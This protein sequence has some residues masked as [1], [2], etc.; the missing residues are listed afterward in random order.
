MIGNLV[1][2]KIRVCFFA[3]RS[4]YSSMFIINMISTLWAKDQDNRIV[5]WFEY[6]V[7]KTSEQ[8]E[9]EI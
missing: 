5:K 9:T 3:I 2:R 8:M 1:I 7:E 4:S 6:S